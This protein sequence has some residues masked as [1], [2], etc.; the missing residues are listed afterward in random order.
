MS[1]TLTHL[2]FVLLCA[3][4][5][6]AGDSVCTGSTP[7]RLC[8]GSASGYET[9][10]DGAIHRAAALPAPVAIDVTR[11]EGS[12]P[13]AECSMDADCTAQANGAC[14]NDRRHLDEDT[15]CGCVY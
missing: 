8:D 2:R 14:M 4:G 1:S 3:L 9:C 5:A 12:D 6:C 7:I 11:C 13:W 10:S 15:T